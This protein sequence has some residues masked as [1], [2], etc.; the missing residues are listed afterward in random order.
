MLLLYD[1]KCSICRSLAYKIHFLTE[2]NVEIE[3][4][5]SPNAETVLSRFYPQG[6]Q[7]DFYVVHNGTCRKGLRALPSLMRSV[8]L[9]RMASLVSE[10]GSYKL[11]PKACGATDANGN[12]DGVVAPK[13]NFL[14]LA[15]MTPVAYGLSH[16][17]LENP[18][19][20]RDR[21]KLDLSVHVAEVEMT[22]PGEFRVKAYR[23]DN[24][25][26]VPAPDK[27][28]P[29]GASKRLLD[30]VM[31]AE[32]SIDGFAQKGLGTANFKVQ[33]IEYEREMPE[34]GSLSREKR[35]VHAALL[36]HP[37]YNLSVNIGQ[38]RTTMLAGMARHDLPLPM[39]DYL[40]FRPDTE[41]DVVTHLA[42]YR[43]GLLE[44]A[45]LHGRQGRQALARVYREMAQGF[46]VM[47]R[48]FDAAVPERLLPAKNEI[49]VTSVPELLR[50]VQ[51]P[52]DLQHSEKACDC[53]CSCNVCCGCGCSFGVCI[54]FVSPCGCDCC[55]ACGCGCGCCL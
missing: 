54:E 15:A 26:R 22:G 36:D 43:S 49:V 5:H 39:L 51:K 41:E 53:S 21:P 38:G 29:A 34:N 10:Y 45:K 8:G 20:E 16:L 18:F 12:G 14:K 52:P 31:L 27:G 30:Q 13:R 33:R 48:R 25:G 42:A 4:L 1:S 28:L 23:C 17:R 3:S 35:L 2:S 6:W 7:H 40:I 24:C 44:L 11:A 19:E 50:F 47:S 37:E 9:K 32:D 55:L 46:M